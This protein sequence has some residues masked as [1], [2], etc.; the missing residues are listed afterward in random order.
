MNFSWDHLIHVFALD[1]SA[2]P[3]RM[4]TLLVL[5]PGVYTFQVFNDT[6]APLPS[7]GSRLTLTLAQGEPDG[8]TVTLL[9][10]ELDRLANRAL[11][12]ASAPV[13]I[14]PVPFDI[15]NVSFTLTIAASETRRLPGASVYLLAVPQ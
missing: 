11:S 3:R 12:V 9:G 6:G 8:L 5:R 4:S 15:D 10:F 14:P 13:V 2:A 7:S 1:Q